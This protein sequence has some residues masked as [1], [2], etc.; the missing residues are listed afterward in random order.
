MDYNYSLALIKG[1]F[2]PSRKG[3]SC[4]DMFMT[5]AP[6]MLLTMSAI[7]INALAL[8]ACLTEPPYMAR[9]VFLESAGFIFRTIAA[10]Y[11][12]LLMYGT[13]TMISE[14]K[15]IDLTASKKLL[16]TFTFPLFMFTYI[17]ISTCA[18]VRKVEWKPIYHGSDQGSL[19]RSG[20]RKKA[21]SI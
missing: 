5:V 15:N 2:T 9:L 18:L 10:F 3:F 8:F 16:Y 19:V 6:G 7:L 13:I 12:G 20:A 21:T 11:L 1:C 4:Y 14:W 17:P